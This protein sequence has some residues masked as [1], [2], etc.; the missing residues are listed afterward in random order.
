M[1]LSVR[2]NFSDT[3]TGSVVFGLDGNI[4]YAVDNAGP[5]DSGAWIA[6]AGNHSFTVTAYALADGKGEAGTA[7][8]LKL[9]VIE[10]VIVAPPSAS[11]FTLINADTG[12]AIAGYGN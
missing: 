11:S 1:Y 8:T 4:S 7:V 5:F 9:N 10:P 12:K 2:A 3:V 6:G